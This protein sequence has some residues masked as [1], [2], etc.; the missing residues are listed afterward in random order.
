MFLTGT[1]S[2]RLIRS[3][4]QGALKSGGSA[5]PMFAGAP[6]QPL[7]DAS[8][9]QHAQLTSVPTRKI[10]ALAKTRG[11]RK[12]DPSSM[13]C[14]QY[15][16]NKAGTGGLVHAGQREFHKRTKQGHANEPI[17]LRKADLSENQEHLAQYNT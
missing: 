7:L 5:L 3:C 1:C 6:S 8:R 14:S 13:S 9:A 12:S 2:H 11:G 17:K 10:A 15:S 16:M 4:V